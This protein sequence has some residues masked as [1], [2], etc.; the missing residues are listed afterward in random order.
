[1]GGVTIGLQFQGTAQMPRS[2]TRPV[3]HRLATIKPTPAE[4]ARWLPHARRHGLSLP[5]YLRLTGIRT[6]ASATIPA[7]PANRF[8]VRLRGRQPRRCLGRILDLAQ[9]QRRPILLC[10]SPNP[11]IGRR[12]RGHRLTRFQPRF[13]DCYLLLPIP[14]LP[15]HR[16]LLRSSAP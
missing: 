6:A 10:G 2:P 3:I 7:L 16:R 4:R 13:R 11:G 15:H 12:I 9:V 1:M 8:V 14:P 5:E